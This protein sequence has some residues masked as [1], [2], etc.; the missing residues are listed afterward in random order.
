M[1]RQQGWIVFGLL[2]FV[3]PLQTGSLKMDQTLIGLRESFDLFQVNNETYRRVT[4][5][6]SSINVNDSLNIQNENSTDNDGKAV[7][8][9]FS[10][11][12]G[13][14]LTILVCL[15]LL[16][17]LLSLLAWPCSPLRRAV[18]LGKDPAVD[19]SWASWG[20]SWLSW[21]AWQ[22]WWYKDQYS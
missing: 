10:L 5:M 15:W 6:E 1:K 3:P 17:S 2:T 4:I 8:E 20:W 16:A 11:S 18:G 7:D 12:L 14:Q 19:K 21:S 13:Q 22:E 9:K